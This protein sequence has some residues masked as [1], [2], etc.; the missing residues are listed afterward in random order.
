MNCGGLGARSLNIELQ[1]AL[2]PPG[3]IRVDRFGWTFCPSDKVMQ[4]ENDYDK[5]VYNGDLGIVSSVDIE[6]GEVVADFDGRKVSYGFGELDELEP[7][8][9]AAITSP[10]MTASST[11]SAAATRAASRSNRRNSLPLRETSRQRPGST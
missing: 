6:E 2:N 11:A 7:V 10:S 1:Q 8:A 3:D 4:V 9:S 5:D